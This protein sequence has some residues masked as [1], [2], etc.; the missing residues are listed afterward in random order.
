MRKL[1]SAVAFAAIV[2]PGA[3]H[4]QVTLDTSRV[5]CAD[6]QALPP[7]RADVFAAFMS[8]WFNQ[9]LGYVTVGMTD[10]ERN[11]ASVRQWCTMN[12][13]RTI[14]AALEQSRP[15]PGPP[16]AQVKIDMSLITCKQYLAGDAKAQQTISYWMS[17]YFRASKNQPV[18]EFQRFADNNRKVAA[19]CKKNGGETLMSAIQKSAR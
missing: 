15:Q 5:T 4:A 11:V 3:S 14:M 18:F 17:G 9:R 8:G 7:D 2:V 16:G 19:Y 1:I 13:Q 10:Y 12:P 6:V